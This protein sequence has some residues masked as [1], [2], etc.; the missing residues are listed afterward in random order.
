M[1]PSSVFA[2]GPLAAEDCVLLP[3]VFDNKLNAQYTASISDH[4]DLLA[5]QQNVV[6]PADFSE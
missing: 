3:G 4:Y 1:L 5:R 2:A 6:F